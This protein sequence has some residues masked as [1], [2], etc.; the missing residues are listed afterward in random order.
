MFCSQCGANVSDGM[1]CNKCGTQ[2]APGGMVGSAA[3]FPPY[4]QAAPT[5]T[6][7]CP[8]CGEQI[9]S[10]AVKCRFCSSALNMPYQPGAGGVVVHGP[11]MSG[12]QPSIVIQNV[13]SHPG[14]YVP[15]QG[16][17]GPVIREFKNPGVALLFSVIFPGG[18]QFY[19]G[20][21]GKG[22]FVLCSFWMIIPYFWSWF[23]AY[24]GANRINRVGF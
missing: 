14:P 4:M 5:P 15:V 10:A 16:P 23:D 17:Y 11:P 12:T 18:G 1:F 19:N 7:P 20:Q 6:K 22:I 13:Q 2:L 8:F 9:L 24:N 21:A 3:G